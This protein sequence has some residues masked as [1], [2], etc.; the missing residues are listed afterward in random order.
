MCSGTGP[1]CVGLR[2]STPG[3]QSRGCQGWRWLPPC[4]R[5]SFSQA[6]RGWILRPELAPTPP[7]W[8][9]GSLF[10]CC[11]TPNPP[12][13]VS[14]F[15]CPGPSGCP[16]ELPGLQNP[17][18]PPSSL[19]MW[20]GLAL[21]PLKEPQNVDPS[22]PK[23]GAGLTPCWLQAGHLWRACLGNRSPSLSSLPRIWVLQA[24]GAPSFHP[25]QTSGAVEPRAP[26]CGS[27]TV[28][29]GSDLALLHSPAVPSPPA[30]Q[31]PCRVVAWPPLMGISSEDPHSR[32]TLG[33][34]EA[35]GGGSDCRQR[36]RLAR[37]RG[38]CW[39]CVTGPGQTAPGPPPRRGP[40]W[41]GL[42][43]TSAQIGL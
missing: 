24:A 30:T 33:H 4:Y 34:L 18:R 1:F 26:G 2:P 41:S 36:G 14:L 38:R 28:G 31:L 16:C 7:H 29:S 40:R 19:A 27:R 42:S 17:Y 15:L 35:H 21:C 43:A 3:G 5:K 9:A 22:G 20:L 39:A 6:W 11:P 37:P 8:A 13:H 23:L 32:P 25:A 10:S 12:P